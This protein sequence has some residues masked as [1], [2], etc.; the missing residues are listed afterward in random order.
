[1]YGIEVLITPGLWLQ[2]KEKYE[3]YF[4]PILYIFIKVKSN[5]GKK[6]SAPSNLLTPAIFSFGATL[7]KTDNGYENSV[8]FSLLALYIS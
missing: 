2:R 1:M 5:K 3:L 4:I 7:L 6:M 8:Y